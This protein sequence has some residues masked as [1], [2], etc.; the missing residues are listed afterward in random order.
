M[1]NL[2]GKGKPQKFKWKEKKSNSEKAHCNLSFPRVCVFC[3]QG[4]ADVWD[5]DPGAAGVRRWYSWIWSIH[6]HSGQ[7]WEHHHGDGGSHLRPLWYVWV[8]YCMSEHDDTLIGSNL[9]WV[10]QTGPKCSPWHCPPHPALTLLWGDREHVWR[11]KKGDAFWSFYEQGRWHFPLYRPLFAEVKIMLNAWKD[12]CIETF[13]DRLAEFWIRLELL[14][15]FWF[16]ITC[17]V[18]GVVKF[19]WQSWSL[20]AERGAYR[21]RKSDTIGRRGLRRQ[22]DSQ[23]SADSIST[24]S[25]SY[26]P[27]SSLSSNASGSPSPHYRFRS[28]SSGPLLTSCGLGAPLAEAE[29]SQRTGKT[30]HRLRLSRSSPREPSGGHRRES[31]FGSGPQQLVLYGSNEFMVWR[32]RRTERRPVPPPPVWVQEGV[33][34]GE[35][36]ESEVERGWSWGPVSPAA[37]PQC[38]PPSSPGP[39]RGRRMEQR[40]R[41]L[42]IWHRETKGQ[43]V[44][45]KRTDD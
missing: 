20:S 12:G 32:R 35:V 5:V 23:D 13:Q 44:K 15:K 39:V 27:S 2:H 14:V 7:L 17:I 36:G 1:L 30:R 40:N 43:M 38:P 28:S 41:G 3:L 29:G 26:H 9:R 42:E 37:P 8:P 25:S 6:R 4:G 10:T 11:L 19:L 22:P 33:L 45:K 24:I 31:D 21:S 16:L 34:E 18:L